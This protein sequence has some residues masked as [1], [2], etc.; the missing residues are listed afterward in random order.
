[1]AVNRVDGEHERMT[2]CTLTTSTG[3]WQCIPDSE[4]STST[5]PLRPEGLS[6]VR[7]CVKLEEVQVWEKV[8]CRWLWNLI[9]LTH[10]DLEVCSPGIRYSIALILLPLATACLES[11][12][13]FEHDLCIELKLG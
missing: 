8:R 11:L 9:D 7:E 2:S 5:E 10:S 4:S 12:S 1:M 13:T 3:L 6:A